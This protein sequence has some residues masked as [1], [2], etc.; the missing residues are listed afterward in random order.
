MEP[1]IPLMGVDF[2]VRGDQLVPSNQVSSLKICRLAPESKTKLDNTDLSVSNLIAIDMCVVVILLILLADIAKLFCSAVS[3]RSS[4]VPRKFNTSLTAARA[5]MAW[6]R[7]KLDTTPV[8]R[9]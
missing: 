4:Y 2:G 6:D 9:N 3:S 1:E 5:G 7:I 8:L